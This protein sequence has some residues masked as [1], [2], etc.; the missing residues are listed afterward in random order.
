MR[1]SHR[2]SSRWF[3]GGILI[4]GLVVLA[5][6]PAPARA[7]ED[8]LR[9][10]TD[11]TYEVRPADRVVHVTIS[12]AATNTTPDDA[13]GRTYFTGITFA[14]QPGATNVAAVS[15][16]VVLPLVVRE[17]T[18][19]H[20]TVDVT[21][22][23]SV[24]FGQV[25]RYTVSYDLP[26]GGDAPDRDVRVT[27]SV[28]AFP[29]WAFGSSGV[30]GSSVSVRL[31]T[32]YSA[33]VEGGPMVGTSDDAWTTLSAT[34]LPDPFAFFAYV[35]ADRPGAFVETR[36]SVDIGGGATA[37]LI[38]RAWEDDPAWGARTTSLMERGIPALMELIG[39]EYPVNGRLRVEE[40]ATSRLG[41][42]AGTYSDVTELIT[43][44]YDADAIV[45]LHEAAH[46][47]FNDS[48]LRGRWIGEAWAEWYAVQAA[49]AIGETGG[50][51]TL[52]DAQ[53]EHRIPLND[54]GAYGVED[55]GVED[56]AY[57]ATYHLATLIADRTDVDGL[58]RVWRAAREGEM[59]YQ[60]S[61]AA[62]DARPETG[63]DAS[64]QD[65]QRLLDLLEER[66]GAA[67]DDLWREWVVNEADLPL[68]DR[69]AAT[70]ATYASIVEAAGAW[71]I[72]SDLRFALSAWRFDEADADLAVA[73]E[74]LDQRDVIARRAASLDL[75][76]S[77]ALRDAFEGSAGMEAAQAAA[78]AEIG[79]LDALER[80]TA[81][82]AH[83][84]TALESV[85]LIGADPPAR[86]AE[87]RD[88]YEAGDLDAA[89][90]ALLDATRARDDA[91]A[92]GRL[93]VGL[94]GGALLGADLAAMAVIA[95]R[96]RARRR[97][98]IAA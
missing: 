37:P 7:A 29:V 85:G 55:L 21:Y 44:R 93:R 42:Y 20:T 23:Q 52:T 43:V 57:A 59:S 2:P 34:D 69:R 9:I 56:F 10:V 36:T 13:Q 33:T 78:S 81:R 68:L 15:G 50:S 62:A 94:G 80:A 95:A 40:A 16:D 32:G 90:A 22:H 38:V 14:I 72:P 84:P 4:A 58:R 18:D 53:L 51:P 97:T 12:A 31:P 82:L 76:P 30:S 79:T 1:R 98:R 88:A 70:R 48:L 6:A 45:T 5:P 86:L 64:Q 28:V 49:A 24:Y 71:Q 92:A 66:T 65:W 96:R 47:W 3:V 41:E 39:L 11:A 46:V 60:P 26:D 19:S 89:D 54:W 75:V 83:P 87:A 91:D 61:G 25:Y 74:V 8:G 67:Y 77:D 63:I 73:D 17:R 35:S 27:P